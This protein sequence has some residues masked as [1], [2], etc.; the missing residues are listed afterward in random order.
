[1]QG[2]HSSLRRTPV[3]MNLS[4]GFSSPGLDNPKCLNMLS[5]RQLGRTP[6][7]R[8][9]ETKKGVFPLCT[10]PYLA[11]SWLPPGSVCAPAPPG[12]GALERE[13]TLV[14]AH[15]AASTLSP[16]NLEP[17]VGALQNKTPGLSHQVTAGWWRYSPILLKSSNHCKVLM[18]GNTQV[19][20]RAAIMALDRLRMPR[21]PGFS[22]R[23]WLS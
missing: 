6:A 2:P 5:E 23:C 18:D 22:G 20:L 19:Q 13:A 1:M 7:Y 11:S 15:G 17:F 21:T 14:S 10:P 3:P 8:A 4:R 9:N 12:R 16:P